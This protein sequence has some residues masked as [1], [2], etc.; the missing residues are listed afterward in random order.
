MFSRE[1]IFLNVRLIQINKPFIV[2]NCLPKTHCLSYWLLKCVALPPKRKIERELSQVID[3]H[4]KG[5][6]SSN[7]FRCC[8]Q[9]RKYIGEIIAA[10]IAD[11][12]LLSNQRNN[13]LSLVALP[14]KGA[15]FFLNF[16]LSLRGI[17]A[18]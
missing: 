2:N 13:L 7:R 10:N 18:R 11:E 3:K 15:L 8:A 9:T 16:V 17:F 5:S 14:A 12:E 6:S 4:M 1:V